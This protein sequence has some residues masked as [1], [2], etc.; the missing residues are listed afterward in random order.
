MK[1]THKRPEAV[2]RA[3]FAFNS[4]V[5]STEAADFLGQPSMAVP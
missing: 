5:P 2:D 1:R 4:D 3:T